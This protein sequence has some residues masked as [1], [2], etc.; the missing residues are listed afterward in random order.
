MIDMDIKPRFHEQ[1]KSDLPEST[2]KEVEAELSNLIDYLITCTEAR[3]YYKV[4]KSLKNSF[5]KSTGRI[6]G[7]R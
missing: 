5:N 2:L 6:Y 7:K 3:T 4:L 1:L